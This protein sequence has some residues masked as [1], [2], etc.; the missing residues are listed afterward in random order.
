M[1]SCTKLTIVH[2]GLLHCIP[3][4]LIPKLRTEFIPWV[5]LFT[6]LISMLYSF[7]PLSLFLLSHL[8]ILTLTDEFRSPPCFCAL[9]LNF[10][11]VGGLTVCYCLFFSLPMNYNFFPSSREPMELPCSL[12]VSI[13]SRKRFLA[14]IDFNWTFHDFK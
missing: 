11:K 8:A 13:A 9:M 7:L 2:S 10:H 6:S 4:L 12:D 14:L 1:S 5:L 3:M